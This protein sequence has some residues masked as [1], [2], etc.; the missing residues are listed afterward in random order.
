MTTARP[1][2]ERLFAEAKLRTPGG[3]NSPVRAFRGVGGTPVFFARAKGAFLYDVDGNEYVDYVGSWGPALL[4]HAHPEVLA[5]IHAAVDLGT[6]F[7][8]P[9]E[10]EVR[11]AEEIAALVPSMEKLR[12]VSSGTEATMA[13]L[14][15]ARG[16]T[17]RSKF[18]K[19]DG[20]YHG[21]ADFLLVAAGS[22]AATL[23]IPGSA[24]VTEAAA[25]DTL[26]VAW[27]DVAALEAVFAAHRDL[28]EAQRLAAVIV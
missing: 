9:T 26:T 8:A 6:T 20:A 19:I 21:H 2:S 25:K 10:G 16:A 1:T 24:G 27:N 4:G 3:V 11:F 7:G 18:I 5:A 15:L 14:R 23:G 17:K 12:L 22:G 28:P 13:A